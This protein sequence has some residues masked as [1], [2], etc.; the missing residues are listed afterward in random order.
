MMKLTI[1]EMQSLAKFRGG[2]CLSK[3]YIDGKTNLEW[4]CKKGHTWKATPNNVK[5]GTWCPYCANTVKSSIEEMHKLA[6]NRSGRCLSRKYINSKTKLKWQC[7][8]GHIWMAIPSDLKQGQ[9]CPRCSGNAKGDIESM[10]QL[11]KERNGKCISRNY[12]NARTK[13][14]WQ[15]EKGH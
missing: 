11:A 8:N 9:W 2:K 12:I 6:K 15:C 1:K 5:R 4:K 13:L 10:K 3:E 14:K 7:I